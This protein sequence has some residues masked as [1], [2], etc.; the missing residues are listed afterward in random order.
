MLMCC[1]SSLDLQSALPRRSVL[2]A[3]GTGW[4]TEARGGLAQSHP[5]AELDILQA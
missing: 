4:E 2:L 3:H 5:V 1:S